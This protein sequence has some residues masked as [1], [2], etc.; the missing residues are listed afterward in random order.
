M[1]ELNFEMKEKKMSVDVKSFG[2]TKDGREVNLYTV[3]NSKGMEAVL[4]DLGAILVSL[5][6]PNNK[7]EVKDVVLGFDNVPQYESNPSFFGGTI[8]PSANRI[9]GA[10]FTI[11]GVEY[12]LTDNNGGNNLHSDFETGYHKL[13]FKGE[14]VDNG[15]KF[16][17]KTEDG[18]MGFPGNTTASVTYTLTDDN[19]L[20]LEYEGISDKATIFNLTNHSYFA[21]GGHKAGKEA[22]LN[23]ELMIKA[24]KATEVRPG[25]IPTGKITDIKGTAMD[26]TSPKKIGQDIDSDWDQM[27]MGNGYDHNFVLDDYDGTLK[28]AAR[29]SYDGR[30]MEVYTD[31]PGLQFY[32]GN[33]LSPYDAKDGAKYGD[34]GGFCLETQYFP[35]GVNEPSFESPVKKAGEK[36]HTVTVYKFV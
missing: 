8:G 36:Y 6:V 15:V 11:D 29:A 4:T 35:N 31:L 32:S 1:Q 26:F 19:E 30:T 9:A 34:R 5:K 7:G 13:L 2:K 3:K 14:P 10:R 18:F 12:K 33:G 21:L 17:I 16:T 24:S 25:L 22:L 28:L 27:K 23:T 20:K